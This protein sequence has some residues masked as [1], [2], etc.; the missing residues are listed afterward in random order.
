[1]RPVSNSSPASS[2]NAAPSGKPTT[3]PKCTPPVNR[4]RTMI[5]RRSTRN[6][7][8]RYEQS[9]KLPG[10][11]VWAGLQQLAFIAGGITKG[12]KRDVKVATR[13]TASHPNH[14]FRSWSVAWSAIPFLLV[15]GFVLCPFA[16]QDF[17]KQL[18]RRRPLQLFLGRGPA[19]SQAFF[20]RHCG[21]HSGKCAKLA[22]LLSPKE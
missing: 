14:H 9:T 22:S 13:E 10:G 11:W 5:V 21:K 1:M 17:P 19:L 15:L 7:T 2:K 20:E 18:I 3:S 4:P 8:T 12:Q 16:A 6:R